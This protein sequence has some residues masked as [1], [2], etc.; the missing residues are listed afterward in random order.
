MRPEESLDRAVNSADRQLPDRACACH[1]ET[2]LFKDEIARFA[3]PAR[4]AP[5]AVSPH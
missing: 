1:G 4:G 2:F 5:T 3:H